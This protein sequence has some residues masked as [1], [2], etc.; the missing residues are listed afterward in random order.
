[1]FRTLREEEKGSFTRLD[2]PSPGEGVVSRGLWASGEAWDA[3]PGAGEVT[4]GPRSGVICIALPPARVGIGRAAAEGGAGP[5]SRQPTAA[6]IKVTSSCAP[7]AKEMSRKMA[8]GVDGP[9]G[10]PFPDHSSDIL[11]GL[12]EQRTQGLLCDVVLL[13]E[14]REFPAHR[15]VLAACSQYFK[16]LFTS[17][18]VANQQNVYKIDFVNAEALKALMDFAY[19]ATLT[20]S[21]ANVGNILR[22]ARLLEIQAVS[23]VCSDLLERQI[24]AADDV[25]DAGQSDG[26][27]D[28][29]N[30]QRAKEYLEFF[31]SNPMNSLPPIAFPWSGFGVP[32]DGLDTTKQAVAAAVTAVTAVAAVA[33][34]DCNGLDIYS[35]GPPTDRPPVGNGEQGKSTPGLWPERNEDA[36]PGGL[37]LTPPTAPQ[38]TA[39]IGH[40][41]RAG[42]RTNEEE[43]A[44]LS[45]AALEPGDSAGFLSGPAKGKDGDIAGVGGLAASTLLQQMMSSVAQAGDVESRTNDMGAMDYCLN[46]S[47][48]A[49]EGDMD[50][51]WLQKA[52]EKKI[53]PKAFQ[54]CPICDKVIQGAGKLPRHIRTHTGEKPFEC[55]ICKVRFT[56]QDKL[57]VHMRKHTGEKPY[58][59]QQCGAAFA[60]NYDLK[61]HMRVHTGLRPYQCDSCFKT[62]VRSD[63]LH[64]HLKKDGCNGVPSCRSYRPLVQGVLPDA[65][66]GACASPGLPDAPPSGQEKHFKDEEEEASPDDLGHVNVAG[67][68][69]DDVPLPGVTSQPDSY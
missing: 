3:R 47:S 69:G 30:L 63:H 43:V 4:G 49:H 31:R 7:S 24:L 40:Y 53:R 23:H 48:G 35:P 27:I 26:T 55:H 29:R 14:G 8:G 54:K 28:Q 52:A 21:T 32:D 38:A 45:K 42:A 5:Q 62:F 22:A 37:F 64:R 36:P 56:R 19:T 6:I 59:C 44:A 13:V 41:G 2:V 58:L 16:K 17:G 57:K 50:P 1:M 66:A 20:V 18:P 10:I 51:A 60:H 25:G 67:S 39:Q 33:A 46:Y 9:I 65:P 11:S 61:N 15:S 68:G 34:D 12:N